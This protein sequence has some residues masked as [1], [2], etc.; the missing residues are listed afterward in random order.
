MRATA[1]NVSGC[2]WDSTELMKTVQGEVS[3]HF[4]EW[5]YNLL[6]DF[7]DAAAVIA[8]L[9]LLPLSLFKSKRKFAGGAL[10]FCGFIFL[11]NVWAYALAVIWK[12]WGLIVFVIGVIFTPYCGVYNCD[13]RRCPT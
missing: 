11:L 13:C 7:G 5:T 3:V 2:I 12:T 10:K 6:V 1:A 9:V 8:V 4:L